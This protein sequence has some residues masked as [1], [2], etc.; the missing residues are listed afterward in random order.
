MGQINNYKEL[1]VWQKAM[2]LSESIYRLTRGFPKNEQYGIISQ[3]QRSVSSIAAN[4]AEGWGRGM[5]KEYILFLRIARGSLTELETHLILAHRLGYVEREELNRTQGEI[6]KIGM[7]LNGLI[8]SLKKY[9]G[10]R[11]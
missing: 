6:E 11:S 4:I 5:T 10:K 8:Q 7:M 3:I 1:K 2:D 9:V